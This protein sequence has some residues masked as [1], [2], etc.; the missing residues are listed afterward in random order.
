MA[1]RAENTP[2]TPGNPAYSSGLAPATVFDVEMKGD[3]DV[4][5]G[6][7]KGAAREMVR[8]IPTST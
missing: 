2:V 1:R 3:L 6:G 5:W 8:L 4:H 7:V